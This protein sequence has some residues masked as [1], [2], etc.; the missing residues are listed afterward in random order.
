M[1]APTL[2]SAE[3]ERQR[4]CTAGGIRGAGEPNRGDFLPYMDVRR[5][6]SPAQRA[7]FQRLPGERF[8]GPFKPA[9]I[10]IP[11]RQLR[12]QPRFFKYRDRIL[13]LEADTA[14]RIHRTGDDA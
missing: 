13:E 2:A 8:D 10:A 9:G 14:D 3:R 1:W 11:N 12:S 5:A 7:R 4:E 6:E